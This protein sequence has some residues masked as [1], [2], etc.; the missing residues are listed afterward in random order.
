MIFRILPEAD[1]DA[2]IGGLWY[3]KQQAGLGERFALVLIQAYDTIRS[4]P[5]RAPRIPKYKGQLELRF[6]LL[7]GF[8][9]YVAYVSRD[10]ETLIVAIS[11]TK[12]RP[13]HWLTRLKG[14]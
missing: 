12:R 4:H 2:I 11:H 8:P 9:Y 10:T 5:R 14:F 6:V 7:A 1:R 13:F 3:E